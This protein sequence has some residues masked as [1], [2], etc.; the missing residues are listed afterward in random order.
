VNVF[1]RSLKIP[2]AVNRRTDNTLAK[3]T[4]YDL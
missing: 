1:K 2:E 4:N 3:R